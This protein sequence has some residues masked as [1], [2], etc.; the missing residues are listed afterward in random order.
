IRLGRSPLR[1]VRL[2]FVFLSVRATKEGYADVEWSV[3]PKMPT[4]QL[5]PRDAAPAGM[6]YVPGGG[7]VYQPFPLDDFWL[8]RYETTNRE[9]QRFV[10][11]GGY[12]D[13]RFWKQP[14]LEDSRELSWE[15]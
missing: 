1:A 15:E 4:V 9:Y 5:T 10:D 8:D 7:K 11:A 14:F 12:Q 6:V 3:Y 13:R 2:P